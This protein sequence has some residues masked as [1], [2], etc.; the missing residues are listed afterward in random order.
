MC[1]R[2]SLIA[3]L[4]SKLPVEE[5][6]NEPSLQ[7]FVSSQFMRQTTPQAA[8]EPEFKAVRT[9]LNDTSKDSQI[10]KLLFKR[11]RSPR[12]QNYYCPDTTNN[13]NSLFGWLNPR[14]EMQTKQLEDI[15]IPE[16]TE[17]EPQQIDQFINTAPP[18]EI[19]KQI[20]FSYDNIEL[21]PN[22]ISPSLCKEEELQVIPF[23]PKPWEEIPPAETHLCL[24]DSIPEG[25]MIEIDEFFEER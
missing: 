8:F 25:K 14:D 11:R 9:S 3:K 17:Q 12:L 20:S 16:K 10:S 6:K 1:I 4:T 19:P 13:Y 18:Q 21:M 23:T 7:E 5:I 24:M 22:L 15:N 2:D